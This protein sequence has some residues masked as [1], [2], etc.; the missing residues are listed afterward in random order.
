MNFIF[1]GENKKIKID[2]NSPD[3]QI[4]YGKTWYMF[5]SVDIYS[6]W[7]RW[8]VLE[9]GA[10]YPPAFSVLG[11]EDIGGG[12][13]VGSYVFLL[14]S[15]GYILQPPE[16]DDVFVQISGNLYPD[17]ANYP[18]I[19]SSPQNSFTLIMRN[20]SLTQTSVVATGSGL[21][22]EQDTILRSISPKL[23]VVNS[24]VKKASVLIP[25]TEDV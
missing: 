20:A 21:S 11:G 23:S 6:A 22:S 14:S 1:D 19:E 25:H 17:V 24:G 2:V 16:E 8:C 5:D 7:K 15:N 4:L 9:D 3:K 12:L 10:N 13:K 18:V